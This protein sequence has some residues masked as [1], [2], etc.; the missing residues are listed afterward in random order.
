LEG[1]FAPSLL[2]SNS[3]QP[4]EVLAKK[5]QRDRVRAL[6]DELSPSY[7]TAVVLRYWYDYSYE[8]IAEIMDTTVSAIK[9]RLHRARRAMAAAL[10]APV[11]V[12]G[13]GE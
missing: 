6:L 10:E 12:A 1:T 4:D 11:A 3:P 8:D 7:R 9:S 2:P 5:Q 13:G